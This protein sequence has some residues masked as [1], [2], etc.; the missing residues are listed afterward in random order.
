MKIREIEREIE[1]R[2]WGRGE[3][4]GEESI[5]HCFIQASLPPLEYK[6]HLNR[7]ATKP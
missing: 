2:S 4:E 3:R 5:L 6:R 7:L 1:R